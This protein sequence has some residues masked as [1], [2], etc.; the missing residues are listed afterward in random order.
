MPRC[1]TCGFTL[2]SHGICRLCVL[3]K[4]SAFRR[5]MGPLPREREVLRAVRLDGSVKRISNGQLA[6]EVRRHVMTAMDIGFIA[7]VLMEEVLRRL[8]STPAGT[9]FAGKDRQDFGGCHDDSGS[10]AT[11]RPTP[12]RAGI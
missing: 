9:G 7:D 1:P 6:V 3:E 10:Q 2:D 4:A 8:E 5:D 12:Y 11:I